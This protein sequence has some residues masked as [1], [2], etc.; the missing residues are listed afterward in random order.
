MKEKK[1]ISRAEVLEGARL[2]Y[3]PANELGAVFLFAHLAY[4]WRIRVDAVQTY[5][6]KL[7]QLEREKQELLEERYSLWKEFAELQKEGNKYIIEATRSG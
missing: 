4:K 3:G 7:A 6:K 5:Q 1:D 2:R